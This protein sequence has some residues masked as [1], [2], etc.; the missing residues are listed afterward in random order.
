MLSEKAAGNARPT[1]QDTLNNSIVIPA[2]AG[3]QRLYL[4]ASSR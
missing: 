4:S 1:T 3:I 2:K